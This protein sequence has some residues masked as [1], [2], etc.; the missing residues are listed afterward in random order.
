MNNVF[1]T[2]CNQS[3]SSTLIEMHHMSYLT[4]HQLYSDGICTN[5]NCKQKEQYACKLC[6]DY[7]ATQ[8]SLTGSVNGR[9]VGVYANITTARKHGKTSVTHKAA[10]LLY[11]NTIVNNYNDTDNNNDKITSETALDNNM[12]I[13][14]IVDYDSIANNDS[15]TNISKESKGGI[16]LKSKSTIYHENENEAI[17]MGARYLI[18]NAFELSKESYE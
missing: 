18:G 9:P 1:Y 10:L 5:A 11:D 13:E 17:G 6:Y 7:S 15:Y 12:S 3:S 16:N 2:M 8:Q 4:E 14:M